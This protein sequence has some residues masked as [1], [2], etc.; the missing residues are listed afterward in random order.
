MTYEQYQKE[1]EKLNNFEFY[2]KMTDDFSSYNEGVRY[3]ILK[4]I[5][6]QKVARENGWE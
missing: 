4:R 3:I 5:E 1:V 2:N 6:L